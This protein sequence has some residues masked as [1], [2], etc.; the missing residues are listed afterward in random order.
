MTDV[1]RHAIAKQVGLP[2]QLA[3]RLRGSTVEEVEADARA[4]SEAIGVE[5][6]A[7]HVQ[8]DRRAL[9]AAQNNPNVAELAGLADDKAER[10][11]RLVESLHPAGNE[12]EESTEPTGK[13]EVDG[14]VRELAPEPGDPAAEH[15]ALL[16]AVTRES[17]LG[18]GGGW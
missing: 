6:E 17:H 3:D 1:D 2:E 5:E 15:D 13:V 4:L 18:G 10:T 9:Q 16:L 12:S 7:E 11:R 8:L 14:G